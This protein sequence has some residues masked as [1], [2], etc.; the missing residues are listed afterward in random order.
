MHVTMLKNGAVI[1]KAETIEDTKALL[2]FHV[3]KYQ[4]KPKQ[5]KARKLS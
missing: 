3:R 4:S 5:R 2:K 1:A